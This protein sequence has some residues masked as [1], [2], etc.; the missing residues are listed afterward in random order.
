MAT[1]SQAA[2]EL[3]NKVRTAVVAASCLL[4]PVLALAQEHAAEA[5]GHHDESLGGMIL[6]MGWPVANFIIF[7][8]TLY[9]FLNQPIRD[10]LAN[11]SATIR[12]DL[13]EA[14]AIKTA[15][16]SQLAA[17]EQKLQ[18]PPARHRAH[19]EGRHRRRSEAPDRALPDAGEGPVMSLRTSANRYAKALFDVA[20]REQADLVKVERDLTE[21]AELL[22]TNPELLPAVERAGVPDAA[23]TAVMDQVAAAMGVAPQVRNLLV[24]LARD[25]K[26]AY[27]TDLAA[28]YRERL[29]A[30]Q[31]VVRAEVTSAVPLTA[32]QTG[33]LA[34]SLSAVTGKKVEL[35]AGVDPDL[36]GGVV[37][38]IGSTVYDGSVKTQLARMR[39]E[40]KAES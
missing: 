30:H 29:L 5:G 17:I 37:A 14:A 28:A 16:Q 8:G 34:A 9:Y 27:L 31:N 1:T 38:R 12:K 26:L 20:V 2:C 40:L 33:A 4:W 24:L 35:S 15:A 13:V 7:A 10:Y 21:A 32:E 39:G 6:G 23:R 19:Q 36:L 18:A 3:K 22:A 11:R 25:R